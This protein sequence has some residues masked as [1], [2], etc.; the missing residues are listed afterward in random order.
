MELCWLTTEKCN[1]HC[2]YCDR[3]LDQGRL[4]TD[5]YLNIVEKLISYGVKQLTFGGGESLLLDCFA[6]IVQKCALNGIRLKL[7]TNGQLLPKNADLIPYFHEITLSLDSVDSATNE[8]LGRG[9]DHFDNVQRA[10]SVIKAK[11]NKVRININTVVT[12]LNIN[13]VKCLGDTIK[14]WT[15]H[16]WR[17]FRFCPLRGTALLNRAAFEI[18][19]EQFLA[20]CEDLKQNEFNCLVQF[21]NYEDM[22]KGYLL[23]TPKGK[24]C[25]SRDLKDV[26]VGN[27]LKD[28][29]RSQFA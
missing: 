25:V 11:D 29:L 1:Q 26:E 22:D 28:D 5:D 20:L 3:F 16:Q 27:F 2:N 19:D 9:A 8:A 4:S 7:V 14:N 15:V 21:R 6:D 23:I 24:L 17:I 18:T 10:I 13:D 12:K